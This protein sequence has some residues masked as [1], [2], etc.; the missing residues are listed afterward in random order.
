MGHV[1]MDWLPAALHKNPAVLWQPVGMYA[2]FLAEVERPGTASVSASGISDIVA[3]LP[4]GEPLPLRRS[5]PQYDHSHG[6]AATAAAATLAAGRAVLDEHG[7]GPVLLSRFCHTLYAR[8]P[9]SREVIKKAGGASAWCEE[10]N[11][12]TASGPDDSRGQERVW[13]AKADALEVDALMW[14]P[15]V[16]LQSRRDYAAPIPLPNCVDVRLHPY[17]ARWV[18][19]CRGVETPVAGNLVRLHF[20]GI[21]RSREHFDL[22]A[23]GLAHSF[24]AF[25]RRPER[26]RNTGRAL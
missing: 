7:G 13:L 5:I 17:F 4:T 26:V 11:I 3:R 1:T 9:S 25:M 20:E 19:R 8:L 21:D 10:H 14:L 18:L 12:H 23:T 22:A 16:L 6:G 15:W 24:T 2:I